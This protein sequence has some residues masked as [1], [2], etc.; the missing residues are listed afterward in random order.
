MYKTSRLS[1]FSFLLVPSGS[2]LRESAESMHKINEKKLRRFG[3][4]HIIKFWQT[5]RQELWI[6]EL[7]VETK[8]KSHDYTEIRIVSKNIY[9]CLGGQD[10]DRHKSWLAF[11]VSRAQSLRGNR[12]VTLGLS[13][14]IGGQTEQNRIYTQPWEQHMPEQLMSAF[15][16]RPSVSALRGP[17][18]TTRTFCFSSNALD[19]FIFDSL[20]NK[21]PCSKYF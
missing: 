16:R 12:N 20:A 21:L 5:N 14:S 2:E 4:I 9:P 17:R 10:G 19:S 6:F 13:S 11:R 3:A 15:S 8:V 7:L 18:N 1:I